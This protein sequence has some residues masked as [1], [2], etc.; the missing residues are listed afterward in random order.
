MRF[1]LVIIIIALILAGCGRDK[2][3]GHVY[4]NKYDLS[5]AIYI[6]EFDSLEDCREASLEMLENLN[7]FEMGEY[8]CGKNCKPSDYGDILI[9]E[10]TV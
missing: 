10:E 3:D 2:W 4:P 1:K 5:Q 8:E 9:C 7:A 6:G